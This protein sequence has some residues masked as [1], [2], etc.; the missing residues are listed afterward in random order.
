MAKGFR[1]WCKNSFHRDSFEGRLTGTL[2][3]DKNLT[4]K[5]KER[6]PLSS[7]VKA[8]VE[9]RGHGNNLIGLC[10]FHQ[11]KTPSFHVRDQQGS[12]MCFGCGASGDIFSFIMKQRGLSFKD[13]LQELALR[14]GLEVPT[15]KPA[16]NKKANHHEKQSLLLKAQKCAQEYFQNQL[17]KNNNAIEYL[18]KSRGLSATMIK[19]VG[20][21]FG[22]LSCMAF[23]EHLKRSG[24][25]DEIAVEAGLLKPTNQG[26]ASSFQGRLTLPL[27]NE[28]GQIIGFAGRALESSQQQAKYINTHAYSCFEKKSYFFGLFESKKAILQGLSPYLVE[29][30]FDA[31][32]LWALGLP[33]LALCGTSLS[34]DHVDIL[35]KLSS[36][37]VLCFDDDAAGHKALKHSLSL[38]WQ[39]DMDIKAVSL[40]KND[41]ADYMAQ[42]QLEALKKTLLDGED[43]TCLAIDFSAAKAG[44][45]VKE[46]MR[47]LDS[48]LPIFT[49]IA[50]PLLRR[51]YVAYLA[52]KLHEDSA[53]LWREIGKKAKGLK[54]REI[55]VTKTEL[56]S[57]EKLIL[58]I[59]LA[60]PELSCEIPS[61]LW[62]KIGDSHKAV[63]AEASLEKEVLIAL[64][65]KIDLQVKLSPKEAQEMLKALIAREKQALKRKILQE[66]I[67]QVQEAEKQKD[68]ALMLKTMA[69]HSS[70]LSQAKPK[71]LTKIISPEK[72]ATQKVNEISPIE[73]T[74]FIEYESFD[75]WM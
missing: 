35:K 3:F 27:K 18:Q 39:K 9:L 37:V 38:L 53:L 59:L 10:P 8:A 28:N 21:G 68:F 13:A 45:S 67:R 70:L 11:E 7:V 29:G 4:A 14:A 17:L 16:L 33:A 73:K 57:F 19:Q 23:I 22:G 15:Q 58:Q 62:L 55:A 65:Q 36:K 6:V 72:A 48:L 60:S 56:S 66:K 34:K 64:A 47:E 5:I 63:F 44:L 51:Q 49:N 52:G 12:F 2:V 61:E 54:P 31:M 74:K 46:R 50:R 24:L 32:A 20:F 30:Y 69:E 75:D 26:L 71:K 43:A 41:P 40:E 1:L 42:G 25:S